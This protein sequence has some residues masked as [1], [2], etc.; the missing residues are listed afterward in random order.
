M[1]Y[2]DEG[3]GEQTLLFIHGLALYGKSWVQNIAELKR[4]YRCIAIDLPGNGQSD[5]GYYPYG[6]HFFA[7]CIYDFVVKLNLQH[8]TVVGHSMGS[9]IAVEL[10]TGEPTSFKKLVL[11]AAAGFETFKPWEKALYKSTIHLADMFSSEENSLRQVVYSSFFHNQS[12]ADE[13]LNELATFIKQQP[14]RDYRRMIEGCIDGMLNEPVYDK[15]KLIQQP[16]LVIYG[17]HDVLIPN[18][19]IHHYS[20]KHMAEEAIKQIPNAALKIIPKCGHLVQMEKPE[21]V[22]EYIKGFV[23]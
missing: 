11:C 16:T 1:A 18:R 20:T 22:N 14:I 15:L 9:Q 7:G 19:L 5:K 21:V 13:M 4:E 8:V 12:R 2:I 6:I 17:D 10:V 23:G 3:S